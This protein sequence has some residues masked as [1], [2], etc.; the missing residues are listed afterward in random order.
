ML[1]VAW[2]GM[3]L[4]T[5]RPGGDALALT[6]WGSLSSWTLTAL[7]LFIWMGEILLKSRLSE[8]M[9]RGLA[10]WLQWLPGRL[11]HTNIIG[12]THLRRR[13]GLVGRDLRDDRQ[14]HAAGTGEARLPRPDLHRLARRCRARS[15]C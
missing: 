14:D 6:V 12:C 5:T 13:V 2:I 4:F 3:E 11:L 8:G 1:G 15:G 9:F 7:P 10:P